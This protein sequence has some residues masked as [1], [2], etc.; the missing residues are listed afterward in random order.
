MKQLSKQGDNKQ[1]NKK[2]GETI[3][4]K[5][6]KNVFY[7]FLTTI[8]AKL[9][10]L[11]FT[12]IIA[13]TLFP[14]LFGIYS[15]AL[16][17]ILTISTF[18]DL[19]INS[20][21]IRYVADSLKSRT[22]K[23][24]QEAR[25]RFLFLFKIKILLTAILSLLL[26]VFSEI[27]AIY[28]FKKPLLALPLQIGAI[29]L[30]IISLQGFF[31]S[32]FYALQKI[33]YSA[34]G[35]LIFEVS[36]IALV[37]LFLLFYKN[38][39]AV[40]ISLTIA[41]FI[42]FIFLYFILL[43][44][45]RFLLFG[46]KIKP[47]KDEKKRLLSF[48]GWLTINSISLVFFSH[49]DTFMLGLFLPAEFIGFYHAIFSI[50]G[51]AAAFVAFGAALLPVFTQIEAGRVERG[52]KKVF[53]Y[54]TLIS[55]PAAIG[56]A[57]II[58]PSIQVIYGQA[59]VPSQYKLA[60]TIASALVSLLIIE[61]ALTAIYSSLFQAKEK[62]KIPA[63]LIV[64][65]TIANVILNYVFIRI[66]ISIA[67]EYGLIGVALATFLTRYFNL[68]A[69]SIFAKTKLNIKADMGSAI[70]PFIASIIMLVFLFIFDY[71]VTMSIFTGILMIIS[72]AFIYIIIVFLIKGLTKE[73][74]KIMKMLREK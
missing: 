3:T 24:K 6:L 43:K 67:P 33:K 36:R 49:V 22:E 45:Y 26:F 11:I 55:I 32:A 16:S 62:P 17:I 74:L 50:V 35:E 7:N 37:S 53:Y 70:K 41:L 40:F 38:A 5:T 19:G 18:A 29:Y 23:A 2:Q 65:A 12:I 51:A 61:T 14:E 13:R 59:Y 10:A 47:T 60:I 72:A 31:N 30:L 20:T 48:F 56:L 63:I 28:I 64:I 58:V 4:Q 69:L 21:L 54:I 9:G 8:I 25:S 46:K 73:D 42:S 68:I 71:F 52:F 1:S 15:L 39:G 57:F 66:G 34:I 27:I 44:N